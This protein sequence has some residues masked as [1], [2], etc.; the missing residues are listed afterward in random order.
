MR[1]PSST[2]AGQAA[3]HAMQR[4]TVQVSPLESRA[5]RA[6]DPASRSRFVDDSPRAPNMCAQR[7][8]CVRLPPQQ[9]ALLRC[10]T[11]PRLPAVL[12]PNRT[13]PLA[14]AGKRYVVCAHPSALTVLSQRSRYA[15]G[16]TVRRTPH[17]PLVLRRKFTRCSLAP[18]FVPS[19]MRSARAGSPCTSKDVL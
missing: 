12:P 4:R 7:T 14:R 9:S 3:A 2:V 17:C 10:P 8:V 18:A 16:H 13:R 5:L 6:A 19:A 1:R 11:E 15:T